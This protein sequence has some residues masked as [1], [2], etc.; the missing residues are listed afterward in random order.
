M[1]VIK[2][3]FLDGTLTVLNAD[4]HTKINY[5]KTFFKVVNAGV[6]SYYNV[7]SI[8]SISIEGGDQE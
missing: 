2:I 5:D 8:K 7:R 1:K 3:L 4:E 6:T